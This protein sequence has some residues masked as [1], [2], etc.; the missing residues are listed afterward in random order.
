MKRLLIVGGSGALGRSVVNTFKYGSPSWRVLNIDFK[1]NTEADYNYI[2]KNNLNESEMKSISTELNDKLDCVVNTAGG[3]EGSDISK[4]NIIDS[5]NKMM[6]VNLNSSILS[7]Y[8]AKK[9]L[10]ENAL[11]VLTG[12]NA[13]K[14]QMNPWMLSYQLS[15]NAVHHLSELLAES[16]ELPKGT[17]IVTILPYIYIFNLER[18]SIPRQI[19]KQ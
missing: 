10:N 9:F 4:D 2:I 5:T 13:V 19:G 12:A 1:A 18:L 16:N 6:Q 14:S 3:W 15:K 8:L 7:A 17:K 11:F